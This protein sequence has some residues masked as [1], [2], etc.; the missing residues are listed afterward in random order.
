MDPIPELE[1]RVSDNDVLGQPEHGLEVGWTSALNWGKRLL[2]YLPPEADQ[3]LAEAIG[4]VK[5]DLFS[6]GPLS[7]GA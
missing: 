3:P 2:N 7:G 1:G 6:R 4:W 5:D